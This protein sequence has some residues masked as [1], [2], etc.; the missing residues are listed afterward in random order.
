MVAGLVFT[1]SYIIYFKF[2]NPSANTLQHWWFGVSPEG[3][4]TLG[5]CLNLLLTLIISSLTAPPPHEVQELVEY[6]RTPS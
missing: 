6:I 2:I 4:S 5:M 1:A 3:I